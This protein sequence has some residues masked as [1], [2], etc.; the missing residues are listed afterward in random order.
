MAHTFVTIPS[1]ENTMNRLKP[2][3]LSQ[4]T[5][6]QLRNIA[7][8]TMLITKTLVETDPHIKKQ[9]EVMTKSSDTI[10][11]IYTHSKV[12]EKTE[13]LDQAD[14]VQDDVLTGIRDYAKGL[15]S[16]KRFN[17]DTAEAAEKIVNH[18]ESY[19]PELFYGGYKKQS[20]LVP[21]FVKAMRNEEFA[22]LVETAGISHLIDGLDISSKR[23][24]E[25][26]QE[27]LQASTK[28]D[29]TLTEEKKVLR[30]RINGLLTYLDLNI[31]DGVE[32]FVPMET[33]LNE[34]ITDAMTEIRA[35]QTRK[36][37]KGTETEE[38]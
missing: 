28:P 18:M 24:I 3:S 16:L 32:A 37:S 2:L 14:N 1:K 15:I 11:Q 21:T 10:D 35:K 36:E 19:G 12:N 13:E 23:V 8:Q 30:Y 22:P 38:N 9:H 27:K 26:Y 29:S 7:I 25:L 34:L 17:T 4:L 5:V 33:P 6:S 31:T 20:D